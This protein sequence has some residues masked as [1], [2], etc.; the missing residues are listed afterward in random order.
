MSLIRHGETDP[1]LLLVFQQTFSR[2]KG[3]CTKKKRLSVEQIVPAL[4]QAELGLP[5]V[6]LPRRVGIS[7]QA[8]YRRKKAVLHSVGHNG[9]YT[10]D[11]NVI[12]VTI[13]C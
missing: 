10:G 4:K 8:F 3:V 13:P 5:V 1:G 11:I 2:S 12:G 6:N 7:E 9:G